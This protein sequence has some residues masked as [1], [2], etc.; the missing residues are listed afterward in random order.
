M[1]KPEKIGPVQGKGAIYHYI[2][3]IY[4]FQNPPTINRLVLLRQTR[5]CEM[6]FNPPSQKILDKANQPECLDT[7]WGNCLDFFRV[8]ELLLSATKEIQQYMLS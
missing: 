3:H 1:D 6:S 8:Q 5:S 2:G 7:S 4:L